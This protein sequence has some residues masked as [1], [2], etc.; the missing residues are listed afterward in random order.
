MNKRIA[1]YC[2]AVLSIDSLCASDQRCCVERD[3]FGDSPPPE[4][5]VIDRTKSNLTRIEEKTGQTMTVTFGT[6][7]P[8]P[9]TTFS[10]SQRPVSTTMST[11]TTT[12]PTTSIT[13]ATARPKPANE[14]SQS[15]GKPCKGECVNGFFMLLC[16]NVDTDA[17][18]GDSGY[19]CARE[20]TVKQVSII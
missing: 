2:D 10:T 16:E 1:T 11:V 18:C 13:P 17:D 5:L 14:D 12:M 8:R 9:T 6:Q 19:C 15:P 3:V 4:L 20:S 7:S